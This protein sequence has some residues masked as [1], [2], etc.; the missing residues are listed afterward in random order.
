MVALVIYPKDKRFDL[1]NI[2]SLKLDSI[3]TCDQSRNTD[4]IYP[5]QLNTNRFKYLNH[6]FNIKSK[7]IRP[8][9]SCEQ[10]D[11]VTVQ[12]FEFNKGLNFWCITVNK[13]LRKSGQWTENEELIIEFD[14]TNVEATWSSKSNRQLFKTDNKFK[15]EFLREQMT[16]AVFPKNSNRPL[17]EI[18]SLKVNGIES[19]LFTRTRVKLQE[20]GQRKKTQLTLSSFGLPT[21]PGQFPWHVGIH[22]V[23]DG[24]WKYHCGGTILNERTILTAAHC[25]YL[26]STEGSPNAFRVH[27]GQHDL[28]EVE[29]IQSIRVL[30]LIP[31]ESYSQNKSRNDIALM[32]LRNPI[33]YN[34]NV[35]P[36]CLPSKT[37]DFSSNF[38]F[39]AG[40]GVNE[41]NEFQYILNAIAMPI[42]TDSECENS[43]SF[44]ETL[45]R[46]RTFCA[47]FRNGKNY[48]FVVFESNCF[49]INIFFLKDLL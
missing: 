45:L 46:G 2:L 48:Y 3:E 9:G 19:C 40:W 42:V 33:A 21:Y 47:G 24:S 30:E 25:I 32:K 26:G 23:Q 28:N 6:C 39:V 8:K 16:I 7:D 14:G 11:E 31:H 22:L 4:E 38:G 43:D 29:G 49:Q 13:R 12:Q 20:C 10:L 41:K 36:I 1:Q 15:W 35:Q 44:F 17:S 27:V 37:T 18:N 5:N 34:D